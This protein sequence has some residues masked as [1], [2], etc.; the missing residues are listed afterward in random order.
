[1]AWFHYWLS[2]LVGLAHLALLLNNLLLKVT[3]SVDSTLRGPVN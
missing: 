1:V 2:S 3:W